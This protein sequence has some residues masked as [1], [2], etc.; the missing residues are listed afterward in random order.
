MWTIRLLAFML[1]VAFASGGIAASRQTDRLTELSSLPRVAP[2]VLFSIGKDE[3]RHLGL[4]EDTIHGL[5]ELKLR[6]A[7]VRTIQAD[8]T[9]K[10]TDGARWYLPQLILDARG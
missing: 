2:S 4:D 10:L 3:A 5:F 8:E 9:T 6:Q 7:G 1:V